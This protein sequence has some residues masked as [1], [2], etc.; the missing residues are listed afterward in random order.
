M[1]SKIARA[2]IG[3]TLV[4]GLNSVKAQVPEATLLDLSGNQVSSKEAV[5]HDGPILLVFWTIGCHNM[6]D[7]LIDIDDD[8]YEQWQEEFGLKLI[9]ISLDDTRNQA[10]VGPFVNGKD[11]DYEV[12][13]DVNQDFKRV[14]NVNIHPHLFLLDKNQKVVWQQTSYMEGDEQ[15]VYAE[16]KKL[17]GAKKNNLNRTKMHNLR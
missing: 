7:G 9:A 13:I 12:Y 6:I 14:M 10:K 2:I 1:T 8:H 15:T 5:A 4:L 16:L 11:W 17:T 3:L